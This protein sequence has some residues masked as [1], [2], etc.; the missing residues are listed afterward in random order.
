MNFQWALPFGPNVKWVPKARWV[1][2]GDFFT[3]SGVSAGMD[4]SLAVIEKLLGLSAVNKVTAIA[5]YEWHSNS[6]WD[7]F[8]AHDGV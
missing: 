3:S 2:D 5:E 7:P 8:A 4:M 6:E 1:E